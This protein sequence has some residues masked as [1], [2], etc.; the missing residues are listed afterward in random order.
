MKRSRHIVLIAWAV[1]FGVLMALGAICSVYKLPDT[2]IYLY[3]SAGVVSLGYLLYLS[4]DTNKDKESLL[5]LSNIYFSELG[6]RFDINHCSY[7]KFVEKGLDTLNKCK[8]F[9]SASSTVEMFHY[10]DSHFIKLIKS[11]YKNSQ[12]WKETQYRGREIVE[13][14][15]DKKENKS[16]F[17]L[18]DGL[19]KDFK[20]VCVCNVEYGKNPYLLVK[21]SSKIHFDDE[22]YKYYLSFASLNETQINLFDKDDELILKINLNR[23]YKFSVKSNKTKFIFEESGLHHISIKENEKKIASIEWN[24]VG[25]TKAS[26]LSQ[27]ILFDTIEDDELEFL[28]LVACSPFLLME[29]INK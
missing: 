24:S 6:Y 1:A 28:F 10:L 8:D 16:V 12:L 19:F 21:D 13:L 26:G 5:R 18:T 9:D 22:D 2:A 27:L 20:N 15:E 11:L 14:V 4:I 23:H 29:H 17:Y 7:E 25:K 3:A